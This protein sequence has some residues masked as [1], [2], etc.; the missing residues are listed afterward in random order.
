MKA[1]T[2]S[3]KLNSWQH[4]TGGETGTRTVDLMDNAVS[5]KCTVFMRKQKW[6][7]LSLKLRLINEFLHVALFIFRKNL[8]FSQKKGSSQIFP[9][10]FGSQV[11]KKQNIWIVERTDEGTCT[12]T[13][14]VPR[15]KAALLWSVLKCVCL[16]PSG[17]VSLPVQYGLY[18]I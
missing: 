5:S 14:S 16:L 2:D 8:F 13:A 15:K 4:T 6:L 17:H 9:H 10:W 7:P 18:L 11:E 12:W 1:S 3:S